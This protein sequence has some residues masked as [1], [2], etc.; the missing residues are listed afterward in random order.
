[1]RHSA[2][3]VDAAG[4]LQQTVEAWDALRLPPHARLLRRLATTIANAA[5][6]YARMVGDG[7][8]DVS[9]LIPPVPNPL[10]S[11]P[12]RARLLPEEVAT[13]P[14]SAICLRLN[15]LGFMLQHLPE[16]ITE[17]TRRMPNGK[18]EGGEIA[19]VFTDAAR[20]LASLSSSLVEYIGVKVVWVDL[21]EVLH[22]GLYYPPIRDFRL[23]KVLSGMMDEVMGALCELVSETQL[24]PVLLSVLHNLCRALLRV[25][26]DGGP[27]RLFTVNDA[28]VFSE[29]LL[30]LREFFQGGIDSTAVE[31]VVQ[32]LQTLISTLFEMPTPEL[33]ELLS[34]LGP[35]PAGRVSIGLE[36]QTS[37]S[38]ANVLRVLFHRN[39]KAAKDAIA[40]L[41][42]KQIE[43]EL[44]LS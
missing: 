28:D 23:D 35:Q 40:R 13:P 1:V 24:E 15:N 27:A 9:H 20:L 37:V 7:Y 3:A 17:I 34:T 5:V 19:G 16:L 11:G 4:L 14:L 22:D 8:A 36:Q 43:Q 33:V 18:D 38:K 44:A 26:L 31:T 25:L 12:N 39:D 21:A 2:A 29:D 41:P 32:S 42:K 6:E 30:L 10:V